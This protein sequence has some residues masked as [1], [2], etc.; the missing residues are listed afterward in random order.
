MTTK[1]TKC[2]VLI[3]GASMAGSCLARQL[4][5]KHPEMS[6]VMVDRKKQ[7]DHWVGESTLES[8]WDYAVRH[9]DLGHYLDTNYLYKHG[10]R[11]F[12][13]SPQRDL[14][15]AEMSEMGRTWYHGTPAH[16]LDRQRFDTDMVNM[17]RDMGVDVRLSCSVSDIHID[18]E[19]GHIADTSQG[20]FI[21]RYLVDAA[22]LAS[23]LGRKL[24]L[25][26]SIDKRHPI[27]SYWARFKHTANLDLMGD[28][29]WRDRVCNT[30]RFL[31]T[32]HFMYHGYWIWLIPINSETVSIGVT[33]KNDMVNIDIKD[34]TEFLQ[35]L[36]SHRCMQQLLE[37]VQQAEDFRRMKRLA[38][39]S[40]QCYST[41]RWFITGMSAAF[42]D[43]LLSPGSAYLADANRM[44]GDLI[45][46]DMAGNLAEY[47]QK[48]DEYNIYSKVWFE[49]FLLHV[50]GNYHG[51]YDLHR[52]HF[53]ALLMHW[54]G[55]ILPISMSERWRFVAQLFSNEDPEQNNLAIENSA[56]SVI[57]HIQDQFHNFLK[58][59]DCEFERN[60]NQ[61]LD[62]EIGPERMFHTRTMGRHIDVDAVV[63]VE[64][65]MLRVSYRAALSRMAEIAKI[66]FSSDALDKAITYLMEGNHNLTD[67]LTVLQGAKDQ[68]H[69]TNL[70][71]PLLRTGAYYA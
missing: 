6:I 24:G 48:V 17:N 61:F 69:G 3:I 40:K 52:V 39:R 57:H 67:G 38:R 13:D 65:E 35:F 54:F 51:V 5:L 16:Q 15:I 49:N 31:S 55:I 71:E 70:E 64:T 28:H 59:N 29:S 46:T 7:F 41:D 14:S 68:T 21:C 4:K 25:I 45:A 2:D 56:I 60:S 8:F 63:K 19:N 30:S 62:I 10:L 47:A 12:F 32:V 50:R 44:I 11:F 36:R 43:P 22:G 34:E 53:E 18:C 27:S 42:M 9:L 33:T 20:K 23:P 26:E 66:A 37:N 58:A 1:P